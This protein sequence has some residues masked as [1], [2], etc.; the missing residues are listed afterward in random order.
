[1]FCTQ[2][3]VHIRV[4]P[5]SEIPEAV[6]GVGRVFKCRDDTVPDSLYTLSTTSIS[7]TLPTRLKVAVGSHH[8]RSTACYKVLAKVASITVE[9]VDLG[10]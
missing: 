6:C 3:V 9:V 8:R 10:C 4:S 1:M 2:E 7:P 5:T